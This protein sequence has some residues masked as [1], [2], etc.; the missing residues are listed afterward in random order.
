MAESEES[1][2]I[3]AEE[4]PA[5]PADDNDDDHTAAESEGP[6]GAA[7]D[8]GEETDM[9]QDI[10]Q[11]SAELCDSVRLERRPSLVPIFAHGDE[12]TSGC[13]IGETSHAR[14]TEPEGGA[15]AVVN[16]RAPSVQSDDSAK[17]AAGELP[18]APVEEDEE[19][20]EGDANTV[21]K[22]THN[23]TLD[24]GSCVLK[25]TYGASGTCFRPSV[26]D[27]EDDDDANT[28]AEPEAPEG[29]A[30]DDEEEAYIPRAQ[31]RQPVEPNR[32]PV[33]NR[34][35]PQVFNRNDPWQ[36][37]YFHSIAHLR[38]AALQI[39]NLDYVHDLRQ[40]TKA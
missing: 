7:M 34:R 15:V 39:D 5:T 14:Q 23:T 27:E 12:V 9:F 31:P 13:F 20:E 4:L 16:H 10:P 22:Q 29:A 32:Y 18:A 37:S 21:D 8:D 33:I 6:E 3:A 1:A 36:D 2:E 28:A 26:E 40:K 38:R 30:A 25:I 35:L 17:T 19:D 24:D 11:R